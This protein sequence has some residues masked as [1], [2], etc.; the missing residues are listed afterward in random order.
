MGTTR[1]RADRST[2]WAQLCAAALAVRRTA[3]VALSLCLYGIEADHDALPE[4]HYWE[5]LPSFQRFGHVL[6]TCAEVVLPE[7]AEV[8]AQPHCDSTAPA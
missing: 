2:P 4:P 8:G 3:P 5:R 1:L 7:T 6:N